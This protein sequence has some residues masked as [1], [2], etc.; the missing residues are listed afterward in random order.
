ML[1]AGIAGAVF[2]LSMETV[3]Y[4]LPYR[5]SSVIDVAANTLG[6]VLGGSVEALMRRRQ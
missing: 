3:Q 2:S 1:T 4:F 5:Y 6:A